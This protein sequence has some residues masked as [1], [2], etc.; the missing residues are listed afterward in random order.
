MNDPKRLWFGTAKWSSGSLA[1][2]WPGK[3]QLISELPTDVAHTDYVCGAAL[4]FRASVC[5]QIGLLDERFFLV[6]EES[7][8]CYRARREG[9]ECLTVPSA[10]VWHK[11]GSSFGSE[12]SPL[13]TYFSARNK[14]LWA[15]KNA[16]RGEWLRMLRRATRRF[17]PEFRLASAGENRIPLHKFLLWTTAGF[18][19]DWT[20]KRRDPQEVAYRRGVVDYLMRRFGDCPGEIRTLTQVWASA[21]VGSDEPHDHQT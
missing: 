19:R 15:E 4:F 20:R 17:Y 3:D 2:T 1:F 6:Y 11:V 8:W 7:D 10:R 21:R 5:R 13:R 9:F 14:L 18:A 16:S 12:A